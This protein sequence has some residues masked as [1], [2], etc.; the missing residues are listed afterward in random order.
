MGGMDI[1]SRK[2]AMD[3]LEHVSYPATKEDLVKACNN[4]SDVSEEGKKWFMESLPGGTYQNSG[5]VKAA[6][7]M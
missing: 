1:Q 6:L 3:H 2:A 4:M 7:K 5:D